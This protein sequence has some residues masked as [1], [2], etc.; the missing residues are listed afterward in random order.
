MRRKPVLTFLL[1]CAAL[2]LA[3][4]VASVSAAGWTYFSVPIDS[5]PGH[6]G[7]T[8]ETAM[9]V[10]EEYELDAINAEYAWLH[11]RRPWDV[12][13]VQSLVLEGDRAYDVFTLQ[14]P[15]GETYDLHFEITESYGNW[16]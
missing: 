11:T 16:R 10:E 2:P 8:A 14:R 4:V 9:I 5:G 13:M 15:D 3:L 1:G 12:V 7:S 6:D